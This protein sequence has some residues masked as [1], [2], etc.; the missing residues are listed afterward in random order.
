MSLEV[1]TTSFDLRYE[2]CRM[3]NTRTEREL[4]A[5]ISEIGITSPLEGIDVDGVGHILLDGF[6]RYRCALKLGIGVVPYTSF[7][8]DEAMGIIKLI[9]I[10]NAKSL[11]ILE[12]AI[13]I[14]ELKDTHKMTASEIAQNLMRSKAWVSVRVGIINEMS[15]NVREKIFNGQFPV[16]SYMY[17]LRQFIRINKIAKSEIDKFVNLAAG[18]D[19]SIREIEQLAYGYFNGSDTFREQISK[20][21]IGWCLKRL[22][23]APLSANECSEPESQLLKDLEITQ[24]YMAKSVYRSKT[25]CDSGAKGFSS[26]TF[27]AQ[28]NLICGGILSKLEVFGKSIKEIYDRT[29][30]A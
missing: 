5:S 3:R 27:F 17:T 16:Y 28:A 7:G 22:K 8:S 30:Q 6:K 26:N 4:L 15:E 9:K 10:S 19:L 18:K 12:Q 20:G 14:D 13:L 29:R 21:D 11:S 24:R 23:C 1:E 2:S 25:F